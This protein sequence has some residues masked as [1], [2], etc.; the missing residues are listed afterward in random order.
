MLR[1]RKN[2]MQQKIRNIIKFCYIPNCW[3]VNEDGI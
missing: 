1:K 3:E 2:Q